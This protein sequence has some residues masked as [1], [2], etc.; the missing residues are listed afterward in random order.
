MLNE[1]QN[2]IVKLVPQHKGH[3]GL[4]DGLKSVLKLREGS[5]EAL[6]HRHELIHYLRRLLQSLQVEPQETW[7]GLVLSCM[8]ILWYNSP[9]TG[10]R[11][12]LDIVRSHYT[13]RSYEEL[14]GI[15]FHLNNVLS[16]SRIIV[17]YIILIINKIFL[18]FRCRVVG[19]TWVG[20]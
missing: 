12:L 10:A 13:H 3:K 8:L 18:S 20:L 4:S 17:S 11:A 1:R 2:N 7:E 6:L 5:Y 19:K 15:Y 14:I 16:T 9:G